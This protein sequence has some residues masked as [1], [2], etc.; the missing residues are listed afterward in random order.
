MIFSGDTYRQIGAAKRLSF[1]AADI[2]F[3]NITGDAKLG[4]SGYWE[5]QSKSLEFS[6][7]SGKVFDPENRY[8]YSYLSENSFSMSGDINDSHY[9]YYINDTPMCFGESKDQNVIENFYV[10]IN[11]C[12]MDAN[13]KIYAD[14]PS[15][16]FSQAESFSRDE[17]YSINIE[18]ENPSLPFILF[19]GDLKNSS[20]SITNL[21]L[22]VINDQNVIVTGDSALETGVYSET[23]TLYTSA[24]NITNDFNVEIT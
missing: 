2:I 7:S 19:S 22:K 5:G 8:I 6:F 18:N 23:I 10:K 20:L 12:T 15:Y 9:Q 21:P 17:T 4:F 1:S 16:S 24:G 13:I 3:N 14:A 11:N